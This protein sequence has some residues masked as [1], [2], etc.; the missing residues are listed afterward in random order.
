MSPPNLS[1]LMI[2]MCFWVAFW[3]VR[4]FL[5]VPVGEVVEK[6]RSTIDGAERTWE[7]K[8]EEFL[9]ATARLEAE[10]EA[11][12]REAAHVRAEERRTAQAER[13][14][15]LEA[16]R[17]RADQRLQEALV[18]LDRETEVVRAELKERAR[19]LA[20]ALASRL[21]EREVAS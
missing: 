15:R 17:E 7:T 9:S 2:M 4:R 18:D 13:E 1:L 10:M 14:Q 6:R 11:A 5:I 12:A 8:R 20:G 3:L 16:A 19:D 21:L